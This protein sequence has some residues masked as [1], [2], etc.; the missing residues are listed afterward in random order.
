M[1]PSP[2]EQ[3]AELSISLSM[4]QWHIID[5]TADHEINT[6]YERPDW[7]GIRD[8]GLSVREAGW[9]QVAGMTPGVPGSG[10]W[11]PRDEI[12]TVKLTRDQW[13]WVAS[14]LEHWAQVSEG[15]NDFEHAAR[16]RAIRDLVQSHLTPYQPERLLPGQPHS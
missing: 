4:W 9:Y 3:D 2:P 5:G 15:M 10:S 11:P 8:I 1:D 7:E 13:A 16:D 14:V 6:R 12:V